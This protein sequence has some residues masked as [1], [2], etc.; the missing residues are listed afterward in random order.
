[1]LL[2]YLP[3]DSRAIFRQQWIEPENQVKSNVDT[4]D[5]NWAK[6]LSISA[7]DPASELPTAVV[8]LPWTK[9]SSRCEVNESM[10]TATSERDTLPIVCI[11]E[12][13]KIIG[14]VKYRADYYIGLCHFKID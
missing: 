4:M 2:F 14:P 6:L 9:K 10:D 11:P 1:M 5:D 3:F 12:Y 7:I 8:V 13:S